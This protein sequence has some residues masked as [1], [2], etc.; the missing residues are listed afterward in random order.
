MTGWCGRCLR[1]TNSILKTKIWFAP[2]GYLARNWY[3]FNRNVWLQ[4][5]V[6]Y[7]ASSFLGIT[8]KC[9]R[10]HDHKYDPLLQTDYY[11]FRAFFEPHKIRMDR[12]PG[13]PDTMKD[14]L[15]RAVRRRCRGADL[16]LHSRQREEPRRS[17]PAF[18]RCSAHVR[19]P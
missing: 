3:M 7:T 13:Q 17:S 8:L 18:T 12:V 4:D 11:R 16:P 10:C 19:Q 15:S 2:T 9:A 6:E 1:A 5:T 14:G